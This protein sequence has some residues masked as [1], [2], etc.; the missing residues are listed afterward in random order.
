MGYI[1]KITNVVNNK[2]YIGQTSKDVS[3][4]FDQHKKDYLRPYRSHL[5]IYKAMNK[6]G[7][8]NFR[9]ETIE[10]IENCFLDEREKYWI[11]YYNSFKNGYNSTLGGKAV[12]LLELDENQIILKYLE[13]KSARKV[14]KSFNVDHSTVDKILNKNNVQR[15]SLGSQRSDSI[16]VEKENFKITFDCIK[17]AAQWFVENK[18]CRAKNVESSRKGVSYALK[19]NIDYY[20][21]KIYYSDKGNKI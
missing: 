2:V 11:K 7:L 18:I 8:D 4:R 20:S 21:Y 10:E 14:A 12:S 17:Y 1:Y 5:L 6:Y 15:F 19:N 3:Q 13:L 9:F 16:I